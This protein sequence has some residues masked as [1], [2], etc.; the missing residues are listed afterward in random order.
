MY[1]APQ[2]DPLALLAAPAITTPAHKAVNATGKANL[3]LSPGTYVGGIKVS[4]NAKVTLLPGIYY[5]QGG[6]LQVSGNAKL[7]G[8]GVTIYNA[9]KGPKKQAD[10][11]SFAPGCTI[12]LS[13]PTE[14]T[15]QGIVLFQDRASCTKISISGGT[16]QMIGIVYAPKATLYFAGNKTLNIQG[17][18]ASSIPAALILAGL[19]TSANGAIVVD[20]S[21]NP[22]SISPTTKSAN[23][24]MAGAPNTAVSTTSFSS[25]SPQNSSPVVSTGIT[26]LPHLQP[27]LIIDSS[28]ESHPL[29]AWS[30]NTPVIDNLFSQLSE[31]TQ[32]ADLPTV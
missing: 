28:P 32:L 2:A 27:A 11:I 19:V 6:G 18:A 14:G 5:L 17:N 8:T 24:L 25:S 3:V 30:P 20:A 29:A 22:G 1:T 26:H 16:V 7:T 23:L 31:Q 13:A 9:P 15:Y 10:S 21:S 12:T 4:G